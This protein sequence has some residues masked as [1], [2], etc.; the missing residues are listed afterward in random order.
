[1]NTKIVT[2]VVGSLRV[3]SSKEAI[4]L[5]LPIGLDFISDGQVYSYDLQDANLPFLLD[6][7]S[8]PLLPQIQIEDYQFHRIVKLNGRLKEAIDPAKSLVVDSFE[9]SEKALKEK[10][11]GK[12][13]FIHPMPL[14]LSNVFSWKSVNDHY[15]SSVDQLLRDIRNFIIIPT[16]E[17]LLAK[18]PIKYFQGDDIAIF[19]GDIHRSLV[20]EEF[21]MLQNISTWC[22]RRD[23][24]FA[25]YAPDV[26]L[27]DNM[28]SEYKPE[29]IRQKL[30]E[31]PHLINWLF[32]Y[33]SDS[34]EDLLKKINLVSRHKVD[35]SP[36]AL[37]IIESGKEHY[38]DI[39][40]LKAKVDQVIDSLKPSVLHITPYGGF[41]GLDRDIA[42]RKM[43]MLVSLKSSYA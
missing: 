9:M 3:G 19:D 30:F 12:L 24:A 7:E 13:K 28:P 5:Q 42:K 26:P 38:E 21:T 43:E 15:N 32:V 39:G 1:M 34:E 14:M 6:I 4:E 35:D 2:D 16:L 37:G 8:Q 33:E 40:L 20:D 36:L 29:H 18:Y 23:I 17:Y 10:D 11:R 31:I 25:C 27:P 22:N 41:K